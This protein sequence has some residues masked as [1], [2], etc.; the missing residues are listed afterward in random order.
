MH[1]TAPSINSIL[2]FFFL[3]LGIEP[4][5]SWMLSMHSTTRLYPPHPDSQ[6]PPHPRLPY[7]PNSSWRLQELTLLNRAVWGAP[8]EPQ[9]DIH[10]PT[11]PYKSGQKGETLLL[12]RMCV[13]FLFLRNIYT[14]YL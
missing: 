11:T 6:P 10:H 5:V 14:I 9:R 7:L 13:C 12:H 2:F 4:S 8:G 3:V 1:S